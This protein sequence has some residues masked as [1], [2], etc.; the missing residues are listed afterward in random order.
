MY[1]LLTP[2]QECDNPVGSNHHRFAKKNLHDLR[3]EA[4]F[5]Q[6]RYHSIRRSIGQLGDPELCSC[7]KQRFWPRKD[8]DSSFLTFL[9]MGLRWNATLLWNFFG[10]KVESVLKEL[11][12]N[13]IGT[14]KHSLNETFSIAPPISRLL[15]ICQ[16]RVDTSAE[17]LLK[18]YESCRD[19][20]YLSA[21]STTKRNTWTNQRRFNIKLS[22]T[23]GVNSSKGATLNETHHDK[24]MVQ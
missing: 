7:R 1:I 4:P 13:L 11:N 6:L 22:F 17:A 2:C 14:L 20:M 21:L 15:S 18:N 9:D 5:H 24:R 8:I 3:F 10:K 23:I 12:V 16:Y 19:V